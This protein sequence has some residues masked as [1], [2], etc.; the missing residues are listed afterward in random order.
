MGDGAAAPAAT[1]ALIDELFD[2]LAAADAD[3]RLVDAVLAAAEGD[4]ALDR[5]LDGQ[6]APRPATAGHDT[7]RIA[8][9]EGVYLSSVT[10]EGFRGIGAPTELRLTPGPGLTI[11][12]GRNGSGKSSLAEALE[13]ALTGSAHRFQRSAVWRD[14]W[15]NAHHGA[16]PT[17][18]VDVHLPGTKGTTTIERRW[19]ADA[20]LDASSATAQTPGHKRVELTALGWDGPL[21]TLRPFL[22]HAELESFLD[23][24]PS[25]LHD[26]LGSVLGLEPMEALIARLDARLKPMTDQAKAATAQRKALAAQLNATGDPRATAAATL[27]T[28][29]TPPI[30]E[31]RRM[32]GGPAPDPTL[33]ELTA[34]QTITPLALARVEALTAELVA[35]ADAVEQLDTPAARSAHDL[36]E[37]LRAALQSHARHVDVASGTCPV[38]GTDASVGL[39]DQISASVPS[40]VRR[41]RAVVTLL[42]GSGSSKRPGISSEASPPSCSARGRARSTELT[43]LPGPELCHE[44]R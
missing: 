41:R 40:M 29:R 22:N 25:Q 42:T 5:L 36:A 21:G 23:A 9:V 37:I 28:K 43:V 19:A 12:I 44:P 35:A 17:I 34:L 32:I 27:L 18:R 33:S 7:A 30:D 16:A 1:S 15:R 6:P 38:C 31:L 10:V 8:P 39:A 14:G 24:T 26:R 4:D 11:V 2:R 3:D 20:G 13:V